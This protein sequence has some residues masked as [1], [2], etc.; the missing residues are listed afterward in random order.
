MVLQQ[1]LF[2]EQFLQVSS[3]KE[4]RNEQ[5]FISYRAKVKEGFSFRNVRISNSPAWEINLE[6]GKD[7]KYGT[8]TVLCNRKSSLIANRSESS[9]LEIMQLDFEANELSSHSDSLGITWQV[10]LPGTGQAVE[11]G[12]TELY[13]MQ[14]E[15][16]GIA[17]LAMVS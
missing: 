13:V 10:E 17:P 6:I 5:Y 15:I 16:I 2:S 7:G 12:K 1:A 8:T 9:L 14:K 11:E 3:D 4:N